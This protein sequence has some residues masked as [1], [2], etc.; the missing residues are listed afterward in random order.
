MVDWEL[1]YGWFLFFGG[2]LY[3]QLYWSDW[4]VFVFYKMLNQ[5]K[6]YEM[7]DWK[8]KIILG[9]FEASICEWVSECVRSVI[10]FVWNNFLGV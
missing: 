2:I 5:R 4:T 8:P 7:Y 1:R 6:L 9:K 3:F 10:R